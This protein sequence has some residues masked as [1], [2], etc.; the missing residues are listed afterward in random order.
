MTPD[1]RP[2]LDEGQRQLH[3]MQA[4]RLSDCDMARTGW[5]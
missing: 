2:A 3:R 1:E 4:M 5:P